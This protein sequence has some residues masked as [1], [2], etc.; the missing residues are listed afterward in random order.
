[1]RRR[2]ECATVGPSVPDWLTT[3]PSGLLDRRSSDQWPASLFFD[4]LWLKARRLLIGGLEKRDLWLAGERF[5]DER[6]LRRGFGRTLRAELLVPALGAVDE[7]YL[8]SASAF[9][10]EAGRLHRRLPLMLAFGYDIGTGVAYEATAD[11]AVR[12]RAGRLCALFNCGIA[13]FDALYDRVP[14]RAE[15][16]SAIVGLP[17][18]KAA[19]SDPGY[20]AQMMQRAEAIG[21][22]EARIVLRLVAAFYTTLWNTASD[23][24]A[25][26]NWNR[27]AD[28][29][30]E[31]YRAEML[32]VA[33]E[34]G[35]VPEQELQDAAVAKAVLP[36]E[37][38]A[39]VGQVCASASRPHG[40]PANHE[41]PVDT[42]RRLGRVFSV[43][44]DLIDLVHDMEEGA[45]NGIALRAGGDRSDEST[46]LA[47]RLLDGPELHAAATEVSNNVAVVVERLRAKRAD[48]QA[49]ALIFHAQ[50][51]VIGD[52]GDP[53]SALRRR[54]PGAMGPVS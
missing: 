19:M 16:F 43:L 47:S 35:K 42:A 52:R 37:V 50:N 1:M 20:A 48:G 31:S 4:E 38:M 46:R 7:G 26:R 29:L 3:V 51:W 23:A 22:P 18:L 49:N 39:Q 54:R 41:E 10:V 21:S 28:L 15:E 9:A 2:A 40:D 25:S 12:H 24:S 30:A 8:R 45:V 5:E 14:E 6:R 34:S 33:A 17:L 32:V 36:F 11:P 13:L 27:L 44:D 53:R